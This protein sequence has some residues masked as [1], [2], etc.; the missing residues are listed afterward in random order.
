MSYAKLAGLQPIYGLCKQTILIEINCPDGID[1]FF[2]LTRCKRFHAHRFE[3][4]SVLH[5]LFSSNLC[6][7]YC[8]ADS[9]FLPLFIYA[10]F[11]SS[12]QLA[13]GPVAL[14]SLLVSNV[15][16][17][18][19]NSSEELYTELAILLA[20]MVGILECVMGLLR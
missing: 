8:K 1:V 17:G 10:I 3:S 5:N 2:F 15:L 4:L 19:V 14:V 9:G 16:G 7:F 6:N 13:V 18:I 20:L 12:R 11:G